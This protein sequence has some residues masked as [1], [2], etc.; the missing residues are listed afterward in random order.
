ELDK[1]LAVILILLQRERY[2]ERGLVLGEVVVPLGSPPGDRPENTTLLAQRHLQVPI[3]ELARAIDDL[4][5]SRREDR[6]RIPRP[7]RR[8]GRHPGG[9][10]ARD[11]PERQIAI[12]P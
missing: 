6:S 10:A 1:C 9:D 7:E 4:D 8:Q 3:L 12:D 11:A 5:T 2:V